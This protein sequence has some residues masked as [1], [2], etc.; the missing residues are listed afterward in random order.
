MQKQNIKLIVTDMDGTLLNAKHEVSSLFFNQFKQLKAN[1][2]HLVV[3]SGRQYPNIVSKLGE[4]KDEVSIIAENGCF[5]AFQNKKI[6]LYKIEGHIVKQA[7]KILRNVKGCHVALCCK[8]GAY[9]ESQAPEFLTVFKSYYSS[10]FPVNDL[11]S[12]A[13][14]EILKIAVYHPISSDLHILPFVDDLDTSLKTVV[15]A[16]QWLD[17]SHKEAH[18]G[19]ALEIIQEKLNILKSETMVFGDYNNDLQMLDLGDYSYAMANAHP[20]VK[21]TARFETKS[22]IEGGVEYILAKLIA[23]L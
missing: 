4:I 9:I 1:N 14:N 13:D 8:E 18:K 22:N 17:I 2:I 3:A 6:T 11:I 12:V 16:K 19:K 23:N 7:I 21:K 5:M 20:E 15:S 10:V